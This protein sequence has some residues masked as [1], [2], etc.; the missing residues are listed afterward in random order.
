MFGKRDIATI[1][2]KYLITT[3]AIQDYGQVFS[4][5]LAYIVAWNGRAV[6]KGLAVITDDLFDIISEV[7]K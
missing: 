4:G 1:S 6:K 2:R 5:C 7:I 3:I